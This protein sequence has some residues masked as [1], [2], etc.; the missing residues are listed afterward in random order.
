MVCYFDS[1]ILLAGMID[2]K[3]K[4]GVTTLWERAEVRVSSLIIKIECVISIRRA[5]ALQ[6][7]PPDDRWCTERIRLLDGFLEKL[8][9]KSVDSEIL[10]I[11]RKSSVLA[12]C[13]SLDAIHVAT[14]LYFAPHLD[15][16]IQIVTLD[17]R[18]RETALK[19]GFTV[20][21]G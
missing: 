19:A 11:V 10:D 17:S 21:P 14:A 16:P 12:N 18:L 1:S 8:S 3:P 4:Q 9:C 20:L 5:G 7:L 15:E 2:Q 6:K 13:R